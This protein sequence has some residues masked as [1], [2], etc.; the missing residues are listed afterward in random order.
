MDVFDSRELIET[1]PNRDERIELEALSM[2]RRSLPPER[3]SF[4]GSERRR[5]CDGSG[6]AAMSD[7]YVDERGLSLSIAGLEMFAPPYASGVDALKRWCA[8]VIVGVRISF[9]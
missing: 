3:T 6:K 8:T 7:E 2:L 5:R 1:W 4:T 9:I